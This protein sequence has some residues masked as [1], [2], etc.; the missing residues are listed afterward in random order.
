M[1]NLLCNCM[2]FFCQTCASQT[3]GQVYVKLCC[4]HRVRESGR[5]SSGR[6]P[7]IQRQPSLVCRCQPTKR[8]ALSVC[9]GRKWTRAS[10]CIRRGQQD[11]VRISRSD[12]RS[13]S[14]SPL[15]S[16]PHPLPPHP[17]PSSS[18]PP[19]PPPPLP[20]SLRFGSFAVG[21]THAP[22]SWLG[23]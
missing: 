17:V 19:P 9:L 21:E 15:P 16:S 7:V 11:G 13:R 2:A 3:A 8:P 23:K 10:I 6:I 1:C 14:P 18:P 5:E 20:P 4:S 22:A 12:P